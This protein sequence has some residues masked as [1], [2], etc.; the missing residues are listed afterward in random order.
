MPFNLVHKINALL[1]FTFSCC[2]YRFVYIFDDYSITLIRGG[3]VELNP[4]PNSGETERSS[5]VKQI[6]FCPLNIHS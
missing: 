2:L 4:G 6:S 1:F 5:V 3:D